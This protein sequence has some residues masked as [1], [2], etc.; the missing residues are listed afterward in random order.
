[1]SYRPDEAV[2]V[3]PPL[4]P[5]VPRTRRSV[6]GPKAKAS[7]C[8][9]VGASP[10]PSSSSTKPKPEGRPQATFLT[11]DG[12][13]SRLH[14]VPAR[15]RRAGPCRRSRRGAVPRGGPRLGR[16][17]GLVSGRALSGTGDLADFPVGA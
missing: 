8:P 15:R 2:P 16:G 13:S 1:M 5:T 4:A 17:A 11:Q 9:T 3:V 10:P 6:T 7:T 14:T 12:L